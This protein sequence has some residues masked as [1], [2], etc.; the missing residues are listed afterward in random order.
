VGLRRLYSLGL[1]LLVASQWCCHVEAAFPG[2]DSGELENAVRMRREWLASFSTLRFRFR[3]SNPGQ[4]KKRFSELRSDESLLSGFYNEVEYIWTDRGFLSESAQDF[5]NASLLRS[6]RKGRNAKL[7]FDATFN[8]DAKFPSYLEVKPVTQGARLSFSSP[9]PLF[10]LYDGTIGWY[11]FVGINQ[12]VCVGTTVID[13]SRCVGYR[14]AATDPCVHWLDLEHDG[15]PRRAVP[16][17]K[18]AWAWECTE[19]Q[20]TN[21]GRWFPKKGTYHIAAEPEEYWF[22]VTEVVM[23]ENQPPERFALPAINEQTTIMDP[24]HLLPPRPKRKRLT[25]SASVPPSTPLPAEGYFRARPSNAAWIWKWSLYTSA[26]L[27][28][29]GILSRI[30]WLPVRRD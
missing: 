26:A 29:F 6:L 11:H 18:H 27:L 3:W 22:E 4:L 1:V 9:M 13:G 24:S 25:Q 30:R 12:V 16:E 8:G 5:E 17:V 15:L 10:D 23:N 21:S 20:K 28:L 14:A 2:D 7:Q 19:W